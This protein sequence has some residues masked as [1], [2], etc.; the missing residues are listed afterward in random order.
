MGHYA[1]TLF[2]ALVLP[3]FTQFGAGLG[4]TCI[5]KDVNVRKTGIGGIIPAFLGITKPIIYSINLVRVKPFLWACLASFFGGWFAGITGV[6]IYSSGGLGIM[7]IPTLVPIV[8][9]NPELNPISTF[10][11]LVNTLAENITFGVIAYV[12]AMTLSV[13]FVVLFVKERPNEL[14]GTKKVNNYLLKT[15][16][17]K[18]YYASNERVTNK[19]NKLLASESNF[20]LKQYVNLLF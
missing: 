20:L 2:F 17:L 12:I 1:S 3:S 19:L 16:I 5:T 9:S 13:L 8:V 7:S 10:T 15:F 4:L 6:G 11:G 18:S 14:K